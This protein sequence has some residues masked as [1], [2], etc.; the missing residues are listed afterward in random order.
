MTMLQWNVIAILLR[1]NWSTSSTSEPMKN[2]HMLFQSLLMF[3]TISFVHTH[4]TIIEPHMRQGM[5]QVDLD[6][7]VTKTLDHNSCR[8]CQCSFESTQCT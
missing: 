8:K 4:T 2:W 7:G 6:K 1:Q 3:G 5:D